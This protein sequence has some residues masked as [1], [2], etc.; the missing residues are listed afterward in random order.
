[1]LLIFLQIAA[2][3]T[4]TVEAKKNS[5]TDEQIKHK[6]FRLSA[7][8]SRLIGFEVISAETVTEAGRA[9]IALGRKR[10][11]DMIRREKTRSLP[12]RD[13][14]AFL[15]DLLFICSIPRQHRNLFVMQ[16]IASNFPPKRC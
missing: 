10:Y 16:Q 1:M 14:S 2:I 15:N 7:S 8:I 5:Q 12:S 6:T 13:L 3:S 4:V 9:T 11:R